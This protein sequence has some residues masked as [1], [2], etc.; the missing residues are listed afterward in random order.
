VG[1][2]QEKQQIPVCRQAG[3]KTSAKDTRFGMTTLTASLR[4]VSA[5]AVALAMDAALKAAA[6]HLHL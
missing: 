3:L 2:A 1:A 6:L 5:V 4:R